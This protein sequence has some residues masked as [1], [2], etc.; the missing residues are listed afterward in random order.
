MICRGW[1]YMYIREELAT[2]LITVFGTAQGFRGTFGVNPCGLYR[3]HT[4]YLF[5]LVRDHV[6]PAV[7]AVGKRME[8]IM[9]KR[10]IDFVYCY[11]FLE[12]LGNIYICTYILIITIMNVYPLIQYEF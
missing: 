5:D 6:N 4:R 2:C 1:Y 10:E 9:R 7:R 12:E 8:M 3:M 11:Q